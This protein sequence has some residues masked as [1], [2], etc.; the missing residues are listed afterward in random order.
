MTNREKLS[1]MA[2]IDMLMYLDVCADSIGFT[3]VRCRKFNSDCY[4]CRM[5]WLGE[6]A[7]K[8]EELICDEDDNT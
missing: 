4:R 6:Q 1:K 8:E 2:L 5:A 3:L 7:E